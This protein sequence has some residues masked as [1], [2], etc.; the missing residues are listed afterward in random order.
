MLN[1]YIYIQYQLIILIIIILFNLLNLQSAHEAEQ[2]FIVY[3]I[4]QISEFLS[5]LLSVLINSS[6]CHQCLHSNV[7]F[8]DIFTFY[9]KSLFLLILLLLN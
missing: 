2:N 6:N 4:I 3:Q 5:Y 9:K 7:T 1:I 8:V